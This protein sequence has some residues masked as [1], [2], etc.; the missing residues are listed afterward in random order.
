MSMIGAVWT[1][2]IGGRRILLATVGLA[3]LSAHAVAQDAALRGELPAADI[4]R[5][6]DGSATALSLPPYR[7]ASAG[8]VPDEPDDGASLFPFEAEPEQAAAPA[9]P[10]RAATTRQERSDAQ[11]ART[12][13]PD[14]AAPAEPV[15]EPAQGRAQRV[16]ALDEEL[17]RRAE[18]ENTRL[19]AIETGTIEQEENP[20]A[21][22]GL[23]LGTFD[24][25]VTLD[26]GIL[27][28]SNINTT[29]QGGEA[30]V[31]QTELRLRAV[32]D[33]T[34][35]SAEINAVG[36]FQ[37]SV[38]GEDFKETELGIDGA[39]AYELGRDTT[40]T[41][42]ASYR[43]APEAASSPIVL[44]ATDDEPLNHEMS[45]SLGVQRSFG[46]TS[47]G[48][49]GSV[50][51]EVFSDLEGL[52]CGTV[53]QE[54]RN[55]TL[56]TLALRAGYEVSPAFTPF[57]EAEIGRRNYDLEQDT[58]GYRRSADRYALKGG[59]EIDLGEKIEGEV[60]IGWLRESFDDDRL[61]PVSALL[62]DGVLSWSPM[63]GTTLRLTGGTSVEGS[64]TAA[65]S[66]SVLYTSRVELLR[67]ARPNL[68][69]G[70]LGGISFRDYVNSSDTETTLSA[71]ASSTWWMNRF[72]G[73]NGRIRHERFDS[74]RP[75]RDYD[76]SSI[77][78]GLKLQR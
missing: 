22:L 56:S 13:A 1:T 29:Q 38:S 52:C 18:A 50:E 41:A 26:Q 53:S 11:A 10:R 55:F 2:R 21:P 74:T 64:T 58:S 3:A 49:T 43:I 32:S 68:T 16:D 72:A 69:L 71:E 12:E 61:V 14:A 42:T 5:R 77:Y 36:I 48:L 17:N 20:Y 39:L 63:R 35:H 54:D 45:A 19:D 57:V 37:K 65:D 7:P 15:V 60:S 40:V 78:L 28:S 27:W 73:I 51:R 8:A 46:R 59:A 44:P 67:E 33:W 70:L 62:L 76:E 25:T 34:S 75:N 66:G 4:Q 47:L 30:F 9:M 23:R 31:S 6:A 24:A